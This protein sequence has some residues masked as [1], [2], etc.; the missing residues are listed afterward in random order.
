MPLL[1]QLVQTTKAMKTVLEPEDFGTA[2]LF[3]RARQTDITNNTSEP[4]DSLPLFNT[5]P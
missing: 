4:Y 5:P 1:S 3:S 2:L